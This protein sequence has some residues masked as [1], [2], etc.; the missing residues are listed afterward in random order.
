VSSLIILAVETSTDACSVA[1]RFNNT[2]LEHYEVVP[3]LH[4]RILL[5]LIDKL[6]KEAGISLA[7]VDVLACG[8]G[9]GSFTG[10]RIETSIIQ[11]LSFGISKPVV[12]VSTLRALAQGAYRKTQA[13]HVFATLDARMQEI[14]WGLFAVDAHGIMQAESK[15]CVQ[16]P[17]DIVLP[18]GHWVEYRDFPQAT[19]VALIAESEYRAGHAVSAE[20][21]HP[22]Y[23]RDD[24]VR[25]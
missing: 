2:T 12:P 17:G 10:I 15:E 6:L 16:R 9:P 11:G 3:R 20:H 19:D 14:Y 4:A 22:V 8:C 21:V 25:K 24:V 23:V 5:P 18:E 1:L 13:S 7:E